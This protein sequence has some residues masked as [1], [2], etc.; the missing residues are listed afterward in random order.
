MT[1]PTTKQ[2]IEI[3][4]A[5]TYGDYTIENATDALGK[6]NGLG[7]YVFDKRG[8]TVHELH[9]NEKTNLLEPVDLQTAIT[10]C[11]RN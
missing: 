7:V 6:D 4:R 1:E 2:I 10:W 3:G 9:L 8:D 11:A 5:M